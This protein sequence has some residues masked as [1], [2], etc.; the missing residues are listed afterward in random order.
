MRQTI[1][2]DLPD[3]TRFL[4]D[5]DT[6]RTK[7]EAMVDMPQPSVNLLFR[8]LRQNQ[9]Q[10]SKRARQREFEGLTGDEINRIEI[11]YTGLFG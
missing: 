3:E 4:S 2:K 7:I 1:E 5:Y 9:G 8:F 10:L 11:I 6:F